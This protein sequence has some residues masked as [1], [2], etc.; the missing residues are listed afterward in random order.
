MGAWV[1]RIAL[2][3]GTYDKIEDIL[4]KMGLG[5][6]DAEGA[7]TP[8][9]V[10]GDRV[11]VFGNG[12]ENYG[13]DLPTIGELVRDVNR[14]AE[15]DIVFIPCSGVD[16]DVLHDQ[17]V[18]AN[19]KEYV[20]LGGK[21]YV[22][23]WSGSWEDNVFPEQVRYTAAEDT[24]PDAYNPTTERWDVGRLG[25]THG[26][27]H[28]DAEDGHVID[29]PMFDWL[30]GQVGPD[31][32]T[33]GQTQFDASRFRVMG[34][35]NIVEEVVATPVGLDA[36]GNTVIDSPK[37][38]VRGTTPNGPDRPLTLTFQPAGCGRVLYST[39]HT[40]DTRHVGM[41]PQ[42]RILL[43]LIMEIT[44]CREEPV[45]VTPVVR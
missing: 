38:F 7:W 45:P 2:A 37:V 22:T 28:Y 11:D 16:T 35:Y 30:D 14:L 31:E 18:L 17:Q 24:L 25:V 32:Q 29:T 20:T 40:T 5:G 23:D 41:V 43:Y 39:Y 27:M 34:N 21:L 33:G 15:Y 44:V 10:G 3:T 4:G 1:P 36:D 13:R 26:P 42:E 9:G 19:L 12:G 6:V 8:D